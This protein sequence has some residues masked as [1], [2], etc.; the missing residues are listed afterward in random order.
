MILR[1]ITWLL[2]FPQI[3]LMQEPLFKYGASK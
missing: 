2:L 3:H 1:R